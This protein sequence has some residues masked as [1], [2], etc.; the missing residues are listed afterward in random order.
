L[1]KVEC[2][3]S[4]VFQGLRENQTLHTILAMVVQ[5]GN[6][7]NHGTPK[8]NSQGFKIGLLT[9]LGSIKSINTPIDG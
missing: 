7:L 6:Y 9:N 1:D 2:L 5:I 8:G 3:N 4:A